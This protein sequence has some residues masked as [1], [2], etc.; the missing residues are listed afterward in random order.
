M[1]SEKPWHYLKV[2][3]G[4]YL[5][6]KHGGFCDVADGYAKKCPLCNK[7]D[8]KHW[9]INPVDTA[10]QIVRNLQARSMN[11]FY[12]IYGVTGFLGLLSLFEGKEILGYLSN[13]DCISWGFLAFFGIFFIASSIC[14]LLSM[15]HVK[16]TDS[17]DPPEF[18]EK[19]IYKWETYMEKNISKFEWYH[20]TGNRLLAL[21]GGSIILFIIAQIVLPLICK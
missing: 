21:S 8:D 6:L 16:T 5:C 15:G 11:R 12:L 13:A 19:T 2:N 4:R 20:T 17:G 7:N 1:S 3:K 9:Q 14:Y 10:L 18:L